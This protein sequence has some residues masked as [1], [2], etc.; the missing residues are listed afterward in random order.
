MPTFSLPVLISSLFIFALAVFPP[1]LAQAWLIRP[2]SA[3]VENILTD[4]QLIRPPAKIGMT[5][6]LYVTTWPSAE[7]GR[8]GTRA[9]FIP[10]EDNE[11]SYD[12]MYLLDPGVTWR[13]NR[14][15]S[16]IDQTEWPSFNQ[17]HAFEVTAVKP[18][19]NKTFLMVYNAR[20]GALFD[21]QNKAP[22]ELSPSFF[23]YHP[24]LR[25]AGPSL[26]DQALEEEVVT[27]A[28]SSMDVS[29]LRKPAPD[30]QGTILGLAAKQAGSVRPARSVFLP[31]PGGP[32][33]KAKTKVIE[34]T[35]R[36]EAF[37][38]VQL[39]GPNCTVK[40]HLNP[41]NGFFL[42][43]DVDASEYSIW[44]AGRP[45][46]VSNGFSVDNYSIQEVVDKNATYSHLSDVS[47][48]AVVHPDLAY[49]ITNR[50]DPSDFTKPPRNTYHIITKQ[51]SHYYDLEEIHY[52]SSL[53]ETRILI[54]TDPASGKRA[55][56]DLARQCRWRQ[57]RWLFVP[58]KPGPD[59]YALIEYEVP[60]FNENS[61]P[62][63]AF[64]GDGVT[65]YIVGLNPW[66]AF[67]AEAVP[68]AGQS[69]GAARVEPPDFAPLAK[70]P[71]DL[72]PGRTLRLLEQAVWPR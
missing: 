13:F 4:F 43:D 61:Y 15:V 5:A 53:D 68:Q 16:R 30:R 1:S 36:Q 21:I 27:P 69:Q 11:L 31:P 2:A 67:I 50:W 40:V 64:T 32:W 33:R 54:V 12:R 19:G 57:K 28:G 25:R 48:V 71:A 9:V 49:H 42:S 14:W 18:Q 44:V 72:F 46:K 51:V 17:Y 47:P 65:T 23:E 45:M 6:P 62:V 55:I 29:A 7:Q 24:L 38:V 41:W 66:R 10:V 34:F 70:L 20:K 58:D 3:L 39:Y 56:W 26:E 37:T 60:Y 22:W 35:G 8:N 63:D 59:E 52:C